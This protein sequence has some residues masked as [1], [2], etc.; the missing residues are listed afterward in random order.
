MMEHPDV[1]VE[2]NCYYCDVCYNHYYDCYLYFYYFIIYFFLRMQC[3]L[4]KI[5]QFFVP[6]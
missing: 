2:R 1:Q 4:L 3:R 5:L 6:Q